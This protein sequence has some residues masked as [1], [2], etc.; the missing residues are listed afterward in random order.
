MRRPWRTPTAAALAALVLAACNGEETVE[1]A[2]DVP[3]PTS[4]FGQDREVGEGVLDEETGYW[5]QELGQWVEITPEEEPAAFLRIQDVVLDLE[6]TGDA[7]PEN[8]QFIGLQVD[9]DANPDMEELGLDQLPMAAEDFQVR[10]LDGGITGG[11]LGNGLYQLLFIA[12]MSLTRAGIAALV[13]AASPAWI[14]II[15]R[16]LGRERV[17]GRGWSGIL[18]QLMGMALVVASTNALD[19]EPGAL[20][21]AALIA[22]GSIAWALF[23]VLLQPYT[24]RTHPFHLSAITMASGAVLLIMVGAP[25]MIRLDWGSISLAEWGTVVYAGLGALVIAYLLY[26]RGVRILGPMKTAMYGNLQPIIALIIAWIFLSEQPTVWQIAGAG[27]IMAGLLLSRTAR[28]RP[29][30]LKPSTTTRS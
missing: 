19:A 9:V 20:I 6:C 1:S 28:V 3:D 25:G 13:V 30:P 15:S 4:T 17:S 8:E 21:G 29:A 12:G 11:L 7:Q 27:F 14:A 2:A 18:L 24:L 16:M 5:V 26:Y 22:G 23:S 10:L